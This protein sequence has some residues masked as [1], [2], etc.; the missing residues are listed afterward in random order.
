[1][2][3]EK[4]VLEHIEEIEKAMIDHFAQ[5]YPSRDRTAELLKAKSIALLALRIKSD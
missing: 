4:T 1:M 2:N 3:S 5:P